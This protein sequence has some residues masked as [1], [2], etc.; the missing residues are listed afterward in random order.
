MLID[1]GDIF[2]FPT[3]NFHEGPF[4]LLFAEKFTCVSWEVV[5]WVVSL[6]LHYSLS[7]SA[8]RLFCSV[9]LVLLLLFLFV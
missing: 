4:T 3:I 6:P 7:T 8:A 1:S 5:K 9:L 2:H